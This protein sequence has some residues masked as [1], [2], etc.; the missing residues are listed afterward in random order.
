MVVFLGFAALAVD[1]GML[2]SEKA[3][4]QNGADAAALGIAQTCAK[5]PASI[6]CS[7]SSAVATE[8]ANL[9]S[10]DGLGT[11][12]S[13]ALSAN[14]VTVTTSAKEAGRS[15]NR[16]SLFFAQALGISSAEVGAHSGAE[17]GSPL[18]G[19]APF[20]LAFS[21]CQVQGQIGGSM[22]LLQSHGNDANLDCNYGPS[23]AVVPGG[24]GWLNRSPGQ[25]GAFV[26]VAEL[27][28][29]DTGNDAP[30][31][32]GP[33][34][35]SWMNQLQE[36]QQVTLLLP[37]F[38]NVEGT[39]T[40]AQ[41]SIVSFAAY[42]LLG[43]RLSGGNSTPDVFRSTATENGSTFSCN[44]NCRG[45]IGRFVKYVSLADGYTLGPVDSSGLTI[46]RLTLGDP[47]P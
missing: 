24:F 26:S 11:V 4:L 3:Q 17:W 18:A 5:T 41:Y 25:C 32:C 45:I 35:T 39:G 43:W 7:S 40:S 29:S 31:I 8:L 12:E 20:P 33:T 16:V 19:T 42:D 38:N 2:Y 14:T 34:M 37:V 46:V 27:S 28:G 22:Q 36:G 21:I 6:H 47:S 15:D 30:N 13:V 1:V 9:N 10:L 23:G 44:G